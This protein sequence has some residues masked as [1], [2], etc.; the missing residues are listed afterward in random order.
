MR[1]AREEDEAVAA[2]SVDARLLVTP[3]LL[4]LLLLP[5]PLPPL[6]AEPPSAVWTL[7][8][9]RPSSH[10]LT[11]L[12]KRRV[13]RDSK[14]EASVGLRFTIMSVLPSPDRHCWRR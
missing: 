13:Q 10:L 7:R 3:L 6:D 12:A 8:R 14:Y 5:L 9:G 1:P 2:V 4:L 11:W